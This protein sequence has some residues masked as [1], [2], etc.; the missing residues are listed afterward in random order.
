MLSIKH[1]CF[2]CSS[3]LW[4]STA[5]NCSVTKIH[6]QYWS[7]VVGQFQIRVLRLWSILSLCFWSIHP[8]L[9]LIAILNIKSNTRSI[10]ALISKRIGS[11]IRENSACSPI[12]NCENLQ[13]IFCLRFY[14]WISNTWRLMR[15]RKALHVV[16]S[17][18]CRPSVQMCEWWCTPRKVR[19]CL[20]LLPLSLPLQHILFLACS[21][22]VRTAATP[23]SLACSRVH[24][25]KPT[26]VSDLHTSHTRCSYAP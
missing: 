1:Y 3:I 5:G 11:S 8:S 16:P 14:T 17:R 25:Q 4:E 6:S 20:F 13:L 12:G 18:G 10:C 22:F 24:H 23:S 19:P 2:C 21:V 15:G 9:S 26:P 7:E